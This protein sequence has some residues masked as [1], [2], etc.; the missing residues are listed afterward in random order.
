MIPSK[1]LRIFVKPM[2]W[3]AALLIAFLVVGRLIGGIPGI[4]TFAVIIG[5]AVCLVYFVSTKPRIDS[6]SLFFLGLLLLALILSSPDEVF[7]SELRFALFCAVFGVASSLFQSE[8]IRYTH[9]KALVFICKICVALSI[10]S[11]FCFFLGINL[12]T[13]QYSDSG[14][15]EDYENSLGGFSGIFIHSMILGPIASISAI[16]VFDKALRQGKFVFWA[17]WVLCVGAVFMSASRAALLSLLI[18]SAVVLFSLKKS[19]KIG[20]GVVLIAVCFALLLPSAGFITSRVIEKQRQR[21]E[22]GKGLLDSRNDKISYRL[23]E[24]LEHP[25]QGVGF[26]SIDPALGDEFNPSTGTIEPGSSWLCVL[27][28]SGLLGF[29]PFLFIVV[30]AWLSLQKV[31]KRESSY[32]LVQGLFVF[33]LFHLFFEGYLFSAGNPLCLFVWLVIFSAFELGAGER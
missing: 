8:D 31:K 30:R 29:I 14:Y 22:M 12:M 11:F 2:K 1:S 5:Y 18:A 26:A 28:M 6:L 32:F 33:F 27:S 7:R 20:N 9:R 25:L 13:S 3:W 16:Y 17:L 15:I 10:I 19:K 21:E 23:Q 4:P 24:F